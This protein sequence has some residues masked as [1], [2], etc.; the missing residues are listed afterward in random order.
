MK[1]MTREAAVTD[2]VCWYHWANT[3]RSKESPKVGLTAEWGQ[4]KVMVSMKI[5]FIR[6]DLNLR[7]EYR[8]NFEVMYEFI[9]LGSAVNKDTTSLK[10]KKII[11]IGLSKHF[12]DGALPRAT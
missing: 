7:V 5:A 6:L 4:D 10:I 12:R 2:S 11:L 3:T 8:Y 9:F 1:E